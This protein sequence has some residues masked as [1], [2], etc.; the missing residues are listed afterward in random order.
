MYCL[1]CQK[2]TETR[3]ASR[4]TTKNNK[5]QEKGTCVD[6]GSQKC[7]FVSIKQGGDVLGFIQKHINPPEMHLPGYNY[8]GPFTKFSERFERGDP[9]INRVDEACK[10]HDYM[11]NRNKEKE[12]RHEAD[13]KLLQELNEIED[14]TASE[15]VARAVIRPV[16]S[17]KLKLGLGIG[18]KVYCLKCK[19]HTET[20]NLQVLRTGNGKLR[21]KGACVV[22]GTEKST[23]LPKVVHGGSYPLEVCPPHL[24]VYEKGEGYT[25]KMCTKCGYKETM[26]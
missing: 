16:I 11:Y 21:L 18:E 7:T 25:T 20:T 3:G 17:A 10:N 14:A 22:C 1:K 12:K 24:F 5:L 13:R 26:L 2:V 4:N 15:K 8:C 9:G 23:F 19:S 6:C